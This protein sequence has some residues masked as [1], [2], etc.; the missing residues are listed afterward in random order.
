MKR[1]KLLLLITMISVF[2]IACGANTAKCNGSGESSPSLQAEKAIHSNAAPEK[3]ADA[4]NPLPENKTVAPEGDAISDYTNLFTSSYKSGRI[5][6]RNGALINGDDYVSDF[7]PIKKGDIIRIKDPGNSFLQHGTRIALYKSKDDSADGI[8]RTLDQIL[9]DSIYGNLAI[10]EDIIIWDTTNI[11]YHHWNDFAYLRVTVKSTDSIIT[12]NQQLTQND[13]DPSI[14]NNVEETQ[15]KPLSGKRIVCFGDSLFGMHRG[16]DS[17]PAIIGQNTGAVVY[18]V[19]FGGCRMSIHPTEGYAAFSMWA[20]AK[21]IADNDWTSQDMQVTSGS[22]YFPEQ[23]DLLKAIDFNSID[24]IVIHYGTNDFTAGGGINI[25]NPNDHDDYTTLCGALRYSIEKLLT[26]YPHLQ[27][28]I[29]LP[30]YR[31]WKDEDQITYAEDYVRHG[32]TLSDFVE[33]L[34]STAAEYDLPVIDGYYEM[35]IN[36]HNASE[37]LYDGTHLNEA[38][39]KLFA[40]FISHQLLAGSSTEQN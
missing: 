9:G 7:I 31:F 19:G 4:D 1:M 18:N 13:K 20:L 15:K 30:V 11:R 40:D 33:S 8:A 22:D 14:F 21:A 34:R 17:T 35:G 6:D 12:L 23:L 2:L 37:Y 5:L 32:H 39:R 3:D 38:G 36:R 10:T 24:I 28:V 25:D 29:S 26:N 27:I 16:T